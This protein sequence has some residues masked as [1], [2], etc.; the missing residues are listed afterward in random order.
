MA[1][2]NRDDEPIWRPTQE[3]SSATHL[4]RF[5]TAASTLSGL[6]LTAYKDLHSWSIQQPAAFWQLVWDF[7]RIQASQPPAQPV[8]DLQLFPGARWF[9]SARLNFA[10]NLLRFRDDQTARVC[11]LDRKSVV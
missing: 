8:A 3:A 7:T 6:D 10:E 4:T 9:P 5:A 2:R 1:I 11:I